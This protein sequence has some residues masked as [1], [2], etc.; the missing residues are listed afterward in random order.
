MGNVFGNFLSTLT[1]AVILN[2]TI[3]WND[4]DLELPCAQ[5]IL[6]RDWIADTRFVLNRSAHNAL[7]P[8]RQGIGSPQHFLG[9]KRDAYGGTLSRTVD[10]CDP[11]NRHH[12]W[13]IFGQTPTNISHIDERAKVV[14][15]SPYDDNARFEIYGFLF[16]LAFEMGPLANEHVRPMMSEFY[17]KEW[18][19]K[20]EIC[21]RKPN[22]LTIGVH[23]RHASE[24]SVHEPESDALYDTRRME[25]V[26]RIRYQSAEALAGD[27]SA[28]YL[29]IATDRPAT[30]HRFIAFAPTIGCE[31]RYSAR[32]LTE[33]HF[34]ATDP[35]AEHGPWSGG[36]VFSD[37]ALL[38]HSMRF[39]GDVD[40]TLSLL[41]ADLISATA[42][43]YAQ[44][45]NPVYWSQNPLPGHPWHNFHPYLCKGP[46]SGLEGR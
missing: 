12:Q 24:K 42:A 22:V 44:E 45:D 27:K 1:T 4:D 38:S 9:F 25:D 2:R 39:S 18:E 23:I 20:R 32:N 31:V 37:A 14:F 46:D 13:C 43:V 34:N 3:L 17:E 10:V 8:N 36:L 41:F 30:L 5:F 40:S 28:C 33:A 21:V 35:M 16:H 29:L 19:N 15:T 11:G 7:C 6:K 26:S